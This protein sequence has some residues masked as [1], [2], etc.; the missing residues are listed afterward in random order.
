V[1]K[2]IKFKSLV[3]MLKYIQAHGYEVVGWK[4][5]MVVV[6]RGSCEKEMKDEFLQSSKGFCEAGVCEAD[7][8][9]ADEDGDQCA[10]GT[11]A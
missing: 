8:K 10:V 7:A 9:S 11:E 4:G 6:K 2:I 5:G 3:A 1:E